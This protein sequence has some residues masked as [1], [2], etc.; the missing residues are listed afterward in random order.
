M[1]TRVGTYTLMAELMS[2]ADTWFNLRDD[3]VEVSHCEQE[4][5]AEADVFH[6]FQ[7]IVSSLLLIVVVN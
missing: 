7:Q 1:I 2:G 4:R 3:D 6:F 5:A